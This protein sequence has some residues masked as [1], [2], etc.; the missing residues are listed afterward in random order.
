MA[1]REDFLNRCD[2]AGLEVRRVPKDDKVVVFVQDFDG[3]PLRNKP[4]LTLKRRLGSLPAL[5]YGAG[6]KPQAHGP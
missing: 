4:D 1:D 2:M 6:Q 3:K 5:W